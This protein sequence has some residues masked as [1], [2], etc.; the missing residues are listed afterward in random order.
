[1]YAGA[2]NCS[3]SISVSGATTICQG[4]SV[5]LAASI[6][7]SYVWRN[8]TIQVGTAATYIAT[9]AGSYTVEITNSTNCKSTSAATVIAVAAPTT[10]YADTDA[11]GKGDP[12]DSQSA[13]VQPTGYVADKTD[14]CPADANKITAGNCGCGKT[15]NS[16]IDCNG[17]VNGTAKLDNCDRCVAGTTGKTA[18]ASVGEAETDACSYEGVLESVNLGFKGS[19]YINVPNVIGSAITFDVVAANAGMAILS[20]RYANGGAND[21]PAQISL[22]NSVLANNLSF[23]TTGAFTTWKTVDVSL[24]LLQGT[25]TLRLISFTAEGLSNIDQIGFVSTGVTKGSCVITGLGE[26]IKS[27]FLL[28]PNPFI[29]TVQLE[30]ADE[31]TVY[32]LAGIQLE[33]GDCKSKCQIGNNLQSGVYVL[34]LQVGSSVKRMKITKQ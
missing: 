30:G 27:N 19:S 23:P 24:T 21:R 5:T 22:N 8:G 29:Q 34:E 32:D 15:E 4:G 11:D 9:G 12:N 6:G 31:Y 2:V 14:L 13:C 10:W 3:A 33:K 18:C 16:C 20:F 28:A 25:N 17:T 7:A 26:E 1:M